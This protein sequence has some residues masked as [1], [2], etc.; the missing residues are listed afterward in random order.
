MCAALADGTGGDDFYRALKECESAA[1]LYREIQK[2]PQDETKQDQWE[3]Q[4]LARILIK[5]KIIFVT[6]KENQDMIEDMKMS[7][8]P[9]IETA[10]RIAREIKGD[11]ASLTIIPDGVSVVVRN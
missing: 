7:Y 8:A 2:I 9:D 10:L 11:E 6:E 5:H 4:I 3:Y 1:S